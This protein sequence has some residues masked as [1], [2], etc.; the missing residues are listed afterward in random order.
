MNS[1]REALL[2][3][4]DNTTATNELAG[5]GGQI[6]RNMAAR[7][8]T[9]KVLLLMIVVCLLAAN[10]ALIYV[11]LCVLCTPP[12]FFPRPLRAL[13]PP[14]NPRTTPRAQQ[15]PTEKVG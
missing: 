9:N 8:L 3:A 13:Y 4:T 11:C 6:L 10:G 5:R 7:A 12:P 2:R 1:Q 15:L 14:P